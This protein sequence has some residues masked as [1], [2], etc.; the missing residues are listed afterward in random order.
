MHFQEIF[1]IIHD[2]TDENHELDDAGHHDEEQVDE[3][4]M[5]SEQEN[6]QGIPG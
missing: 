2:E 3:E 5:I 6:T 1:D 4:E